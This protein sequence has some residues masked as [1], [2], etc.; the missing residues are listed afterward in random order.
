MIQGL[1]QYNMMTVHSG[2]TSIIYCYNNS[3][4]CD[5]HKKMLV[6]KV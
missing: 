5:F 2:E 1:Y 3:F 4:Q 6:T